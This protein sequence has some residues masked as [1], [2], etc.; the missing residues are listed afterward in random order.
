MFEYESSEDEEW[1]GAQT[2]QAASQLNEVMV[3]DSSEDEWVS[4]TESSESSED[5]SHVP[6]TPIS[7]ASQAPPRAAGTDVHPRK[8]KREWEKREWDRFKQYSD[9]VI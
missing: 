6:E 4:A 5:E 7:V 2:A 1:S 8:R 3:P 9:W